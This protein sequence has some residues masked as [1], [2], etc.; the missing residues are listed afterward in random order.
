MSQSVLGNISLCY[1]L[2]WDRRRR[3]VAVR[4]FLEEN[5]NGLVD[6]QQLVTAIAQQWPM[7]A[8]LLILCTSSGTLL[9]ALLDCN[10]PSNIWVQAH[11]HWL[12]DPLFMDKLGAAK[13]RGLS[14]VW[15]GDPGH[16]PST[17]Q[18][19]LL[20]QV[21]LELTAEQA[22][23]A[24]RAAVKNPQSGLVETASASP[25]LA[26]CMYGSLANK[27]LIDHA[28]DQQ[29]AWAVSGWPTEEILHGYEASKLEPNK[30][31]IESLINAVDADQSMDELE[32]RL[33]ADPLLA[34]RFLRHVNSAAIGLKREADSL[35]LGLASL[36][37]SKFR[38]WLTELFPNSS[39][40]RDLDPIRKSMV[41]RGRIMERLINTGAEEELRRELFLCAILSQIDLLLGEPLPDCLQRV[42]L[43]ERVQQALINHSGPYASLLAMCKAL[44]SGNTSV[45][46]GISET[47][48]LPAED[49]NLTLLHVLS[50]I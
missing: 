15:Q 26:D 8:P 7:D 33:G 2:V 35:R 38:N 47:S 10:A 50:D 36:G 43:P 1:E 12:A 28:L 32:Q 9:S 27:A 17:Q 25:V 4:L 40:E 5:E 46:R 42:P 3:C 14:T 41:L 45:V 11:E 24:M 39:T 6:A 23:Q 31:V 13:Q 44:E 20:R 30:G 22:L 29:G 34:Y 21:L 16:A 49:V 48:M 37:Y 19:A 18:Q